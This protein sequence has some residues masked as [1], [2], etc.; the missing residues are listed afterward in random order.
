MNNLVAGLNFQ[1]LVKI[2]LT[3]EQ[4]QKMA[5]AVMPLVQLKL[6]TKVEEALGAEKMIELK[7]EADKKKLDFV[8]SLDLIDAAY[9]QKTGQYLM[10]QMRLLINEHLELMAKVIVRAKADGAKLAQSGLVEQLEKLLDEGK[11]GEAAKLIEQE[12]K[13]AA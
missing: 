3:P 6:Q 4:A 13:H 11:T 5:A 12:L 2:G 1:P 8:A 10:E 9:R 7:A